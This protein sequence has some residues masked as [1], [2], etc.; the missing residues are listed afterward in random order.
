VHASRDTRPFPFTCDVIPERD[1]VRIAPVGEL[2]IAAMP[3]L[4]QTV[5]ELRDS[6]F[7]YLIVDLRRLSFIDSSGLR[8]L[9]ELQS[10]ANADSHRLELVPGP[11]EVQKV[12][13]I[14]GTLKA[15]PFRDATVDG[16]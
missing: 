3:L 2:D 16:R 13:E 4:D 15:L 5:R 10:A 6:G 12:F 1:H 8:L 7:D 11:P 9:L 14:S